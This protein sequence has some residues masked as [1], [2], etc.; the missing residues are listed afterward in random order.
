MELIQQLP[1]ELVTLE[2]EQY[3]EFVSS[4]ATLRT[5]IQNWQ[6][7]GSYAFHHIS[8]FRRLS[9]IALIR[10]ALAKC[11][12]EFPST[13]I[14]ELTFIEDEDLRETLG[15]DIGA[16]N[17]AF[18]NLEWK[19]ATVL[20]GSVIEA[21]LLWALEKKPGEVQASVKRLVDDKTFKSKPAADLNDWNLF[22]YSKVAADLKL[23]D[24][25]TVSQVD[26]ARDYRNLIHPGKVKRSQ[27]C[28]RAT[29]M[30]AV[31]AMERV[32]QDLGKRFP[33]EIKPLFFC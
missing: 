8:G 20:A 27:P 4:S 3:A 7:A 32:K 31:A 15:R 9:P 33:T 28:S 25:D 21:L 19:A 5:L 23:L 12:D 22:L 26:L 30:T 17:S 6:T 13:S 24:G 16:V 14:S 11:H 29:A 18:S 10:E 1:S 2:S